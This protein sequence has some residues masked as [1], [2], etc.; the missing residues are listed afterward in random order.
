MIKAILAVD[1]KYGVS[2]NGSMPWPSNSLDL[3]WF[4]KNTKENVIVM[5]SLTW[6]DPKMPTPLKKRINVLITSKDSNY[7]PGADIYA[8]GNIE[9]TVNNIQE[10]FPDKLIWIIGGPNIIEQSFSLIEE[11]YLTRI[12]GNYNCDTFLD[13][14]RIEKEMK[15]NKHIDGDKTCHF[16]IWKK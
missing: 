6:R 16:E 8:K 13:V 10:K 5:G 2:K 3:S 15:K 4:S 11:F 14:K 12:Y 9:N 7:Y 1:D